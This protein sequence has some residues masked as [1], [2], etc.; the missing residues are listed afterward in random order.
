MTPPAFAERAFEF[1]CDMVHL[2][3]KLIKT[4]D[5]PF[6]IARQLLRSA[7]SIGANI[8]EARGG[9]SR[10]DL[11]H[12]YAVAVREARETKY[13]LRL[14]QATKLASQIQLDGAI[15][16]VDQLVAMLTTSVRTLKERNG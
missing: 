5:F 4:R 14:I 2:H 3:R 1:A 13:W 8:E 7:T 10:R 6:S 9:S 11:A 12:R 16:E 15:D